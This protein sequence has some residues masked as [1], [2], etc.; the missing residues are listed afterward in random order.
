M[1]RLTPDQ[2]SIYD[3]WLAS[4]AD[5]DPR[6]LSLLE[7]SLGRIAAGLLH[8]QLARRG[9]GAV[10]KM[11]DLSGT[12]LGSEHAEALVAWLR[13]AIEQDEDWL[14]DIDEDGVPRRLAACGDYLDMLKAARD[15]YNEK[16]FPVPGR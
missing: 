4:L 15:D 5:G 6:L 3:E 14:R 12:R 16:P 2:R 11:G 10:M 13:N 7:V 8:E 9:P 1:H